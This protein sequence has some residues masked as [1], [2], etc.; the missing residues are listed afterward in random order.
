MPERLIHG[1]HRESSPTAGHEVARLQPTH[2]RPACAE[3]LASLSDSALARWWDEPVVQDFYA[4][5]ADSYLAGLDRLADS[6]C[7]G[8]GIVICGGGKY[9]ASAYVTIR[10]LRHLGCALPIQLWYLGRLGEMDDELISLVKPYG[11]E[12]VDADRVRAIH[13][14]RI[15]N[16]FQ[17]KPFATRH[18]AF[19]EVLF[20]DADCYPA[21]DPSTLF[22]CPGYRSTGALFWSDL[23]HTAAWTN[24]AAFQVKPD[25]RPPFESGQFLIDKWRCAPAL[26]LALWYNNHSDFTYRHAYGDKDLWHIAFAR[27]GQTFAMYAPQPIWLGPA[28]VHAGSDQQPQFVHRC[29]DKYTLAESTFPTP[30]SSAFSAG[31]GLPLEAECQGWLAELRNLLK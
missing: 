24:W 22:A 30:Q 2:L 17:L 15:L 8:P 12:C 6:S 18:C 28:Y 13:P 25:G 27:C 26:G 3:I 14:I 5:A 29:R 20:L 1:M 7:A 16:G 31:C 19:G 9:F 4:R 21:R 10:A 23:P 11:V